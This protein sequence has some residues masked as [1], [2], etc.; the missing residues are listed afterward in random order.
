MKKLQHWCSFSILILCV[1]FTLALTGCS[2]GSTELKNTVSAYTKMLAEA[3]AKPDAGMME[4]FTTP[5]EKKRIE[6][7]IDYLRKDK[8][9][10]INTLKSIDFKSAEIDK[11]KK[12]AIV[13]TREEWTYHYID[14]KS[15]QPISKEEAISYNNI[16]HLIQEK[17]H[18]VVEK[19][20]MNETR[21]PVPAPSE[22]S[23]EKSPENDMSGDKNKV[24][25]PEKFK[26]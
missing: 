11:V 22:T 3:L 9:L 16:Y 4:F 7:Y 17:G 14:E 13:V 24:K 5:F 23:R 1:I 10:I 21:S 19:V 26:F 15:R 8:K 25:P 12:T 2:R 6:S 20:D 18:W